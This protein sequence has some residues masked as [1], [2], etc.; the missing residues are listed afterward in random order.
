MK[1]RFSPEHKFIFC[2]IDGSH[3]PKYVI[4]DFYTVGYNVVPGG[5][6]GFH[7]YGGDIPHVTET[8]D[9]LI[10]KHRDEIRGTEQFE[11]TI[12]LTKS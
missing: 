9:D 10:E 4:N 3:T 1:I 2:F 11:D 5:A 12:F 8:I 7:D 6:V